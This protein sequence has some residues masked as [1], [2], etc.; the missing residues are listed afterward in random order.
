M[1]QRRYGRLPLILALLL[2]LSLCIGLVAYFRSAPAPASAPEA[3][4]PPGTETAFLR[5]NM[6]AMDRMMAGMNVAATGDI[7][8]DFTLMMIPHHQGAIDM[9]QALL[10]HGKNEELRA[11]ARGIIA[12]QE[13]EIAMMRRIGGEQ[14]PPAEM[15]VASGSHHHAPH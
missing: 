14:A 10:R 4:A 1:N 11:L 6:T 7:D 13:E 2:T 5:E 12:K 3:A 15:P 9:A 8:R